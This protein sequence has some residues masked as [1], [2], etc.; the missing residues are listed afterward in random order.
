MTD[1]CISKVNDSSMI[2][3]SLDDPELV[4]YIKVYKKMKTEYI[5]KCESLFRILEND[6]LMKSK[7]DDKD[8]NP[9][10]TIR[11]FGY[12]DLVAIET[13]VRDQLVDMYSKCHEYYQSGIVE[14]FNAL[15]EKN[16]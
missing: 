4:G 12:G 15:K 6:I 11:N 7:V 9:H 3:L 14:L 16:V 1:F 10:F 5:K 13:T 8:E 2:P